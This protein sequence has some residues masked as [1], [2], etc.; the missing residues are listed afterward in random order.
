MDLTFNGKDCQVLNFTDLTMYV[1]LRREE[2]KSRLLSTLNM[3]IHH[4]MLG[5]LK[6]NVDMASYLIK[7]LN[8]E[9]SSACTRKMAKAIL[10]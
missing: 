9:N 6:A 4:E 7:N 1:K 2:E 3:S 10:V 8:R 5:P